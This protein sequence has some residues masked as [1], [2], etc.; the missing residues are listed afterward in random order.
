MDEDV[1]VVNVRDWTNP[2]WINKSMN[3]LASIYL[4]TNDNTF[5]DGGKSA[6]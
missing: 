3:G 1:F 5:T 6:F 4:S 2:L